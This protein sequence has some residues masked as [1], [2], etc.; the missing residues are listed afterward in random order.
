[1]GQDGG[2]QDGWEA[3]RTPT[4]LR[5]RTDVRIPCQTHG[6]RS[7]CV[8]VRG[9]AALIEDVYAAAERGGEGARVRRQ[10]SRGHGGQ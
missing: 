6:A 10:I 9:M 5:F 8:L 4:A 2:Q 1:M 7:G 3:L